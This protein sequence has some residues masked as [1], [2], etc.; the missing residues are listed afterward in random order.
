MV[1]FIET[2]ISPKYKDNLIILDNAGRHNNDMVKK[3][4]LKSGNQYLFFTIFAFPNCDY[5]ITIIYYNIL[6]L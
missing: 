3:A 6:S 5:I 4:I 1:E 2:Q